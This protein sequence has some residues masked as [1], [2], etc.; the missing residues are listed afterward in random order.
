[1]DPGQTYRYAER[2]V[3][4]IGCQRMSPAGWQ[5]YAG[6]VQGMLLALDTGDVEE[7]AAVTTAMT[8]LAI[9]HQKTLGDTSRVEQPA[10]LRPATEALLAALATL[11]ASH[12][13][14][15]D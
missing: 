2:T 1:M 7:L 15:G 4:T 14:T 6:A 3:R 10:P 12:Q 11:I 8:T 5:R 13:P 9:P